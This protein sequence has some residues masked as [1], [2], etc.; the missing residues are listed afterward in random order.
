MWY[1]TASVEVP[2]VNV[3]YVN[4]HGGEKQMA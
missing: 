1:I 3:R 4:D 2:Y